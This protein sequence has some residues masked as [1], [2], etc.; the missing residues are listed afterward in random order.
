L[1]QAA[2]RIPS[3]PPHLLVRMVRLGGP[4]DSCS[5][6]NRT[7]LLAFRNK[8]DLGSKE[9][10]G[11]EAA[12]VK[13]YWSTLAI[14]EKVAILRFQ[15]RALVNELYD[16]QQSLYS[17]DVECFIHGFHGQE[18]VRLKTGI[19]HFDVE[20]ILD[21][22]RRLCPKAFIAHRTLIEMD[23]MFDFFEERLGRPFLQDVPNLAEGQWASLLKPQ[24]SSWLDFMRVCIQLVELVL[25]KSQQEALRKSQ[26]EECSKPRE[27]DTPAGAP[28]QHAKRRARKKRV[29]IGSAAATDEPAE[30]QGLATS[31][32]HHDSVSTHVQDVGLSVAGAPIEGSEAGK[33][34]PRSTLDESDV[35]PVAMKAD[36]MPL[37]AVS[38]ALRQSAREARMRSCSASSR[39][40]V[41]CSASPRGRVPRDGSLGSSGSPRA[42]VSFSPQPALQ[43]RSSTEETGTFSAPTVGEDGPAWTTISRRN[44]TR[45]RPEAESAEMRGWSSSE[46]CD[47]DPLLAASQ[48]LRHTA[49]EARFSAGVTPVLMAS[50]ALRA[51]ARES[52]VR[53]EN[54]MREERGRARVR[55]APWLL[56]DGSSGENWVD[57]FRAT[58]KNTFLDI[59]QVEMECSVLRAKSCPAY[60][61]PVFTFGGA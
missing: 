15:D 37:L 9:A 10:V 40:S 29:Q 20:G 31:S 3:S 18:Q 44:K 25:R 59:E 12:T 2:S 30:L 52:W 6:R 27:P 49:R 13:Q 28:S 58:V 53:A 24:P 32:T 5:S 60:L 14:D 35:L 17:A 43:P 7:R 61:Y 33:A 48:S 19:Q 1:Y 34:T 41:C 16:I 57:G 39:E 50:Q 8:Q 51:C 47:A 4:S 56:A 55:A 54:Q 38:Q 23:N 21:K 46:H 11:S 45:C 22:N 26:R 36:T 42:S